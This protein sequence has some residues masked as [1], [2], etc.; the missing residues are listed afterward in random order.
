MSQSQKASQAYPPSRD[1]A[2]GPKRASP[3]KSGQIRPMARGGQGLTLASHPDAGGPLT[4]ADPEGPEQ[5]GG[6]CIWGLFGRSR[7]KSPR[8]AGCSVPGRRPV[9]NRHRGLGLKPEPSVAQRGEA[10]AGSHRDRR[11]PGEP[12][13]SPSKFWSPRGSHSP[14]TMPPPPTREL[15]RPPPLL[16][17]TVS[18]QL[19]SLSL[20]SGAT[21]SGSVLPTALLPCPHALALLVLLPLLYNIIIS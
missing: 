12:L 6:G 15:A 9:L 16:F 1:L 19:A 14:L 11:V 17:L 21:G 4:D 3:Q 5:G 20:C 7:S 10:R 18:R 2:H 13:P 8:G